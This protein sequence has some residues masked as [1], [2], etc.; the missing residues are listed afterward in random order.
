MP[1]LSRRATLLGLAT[2]LTAGPVAL[3]F[4]AA[5]TEQRFVVILLRGALDGLAAVQ[6]YGDPALRDLRGDL[7]LPEPG[8]ANGVLDL[9]GFHGLHPAL[10]GLHDLYK[11]NELAVIHAVA[12]PTRSRSHFEAQD[13]LESGADHRMTSG[14]L[15]RAATLL[16]T[17][18]GGSEAALAVGTSVGLMLRGPAPV[19]TWMPQTFAQPDPALYRALAALHHPDPITGPAIAEGLHERGFTE[20][21]LNGQEAPKDKYSFPALATAAGKL[22]ADANGPRIAVLEL[23]GWD[24]H[25]AQKARL[26]GVLG[27]LDRGIT[28]LKSGLGAAWSRTAVLVMTEFGR[29]VRTNGTAGTDHGTGGVA[30]LAGGAIAGGR[31]LGPWPGLADL[32]DNRDLTPTTDLRSIA[33]GVLAAHFKLGSDRLAAVF[34]DSTAAMAM[35][36]LLKPYG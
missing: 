2:T 25:A 16:P 18:P 4:A 3:A 28:G 8:Q 27:A 26:P 22:L 9:G 6:P 32:L 17:R 36:G 13:Y 24:T 12:G 7:T 30:F 19:G 34:P 31:I 10:A 5:V 23:G 15:N 35:K 14:W 1:P 33:K 20:A 29:T 21:V 11:G